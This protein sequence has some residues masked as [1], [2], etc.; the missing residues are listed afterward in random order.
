M[1]LG[2][3]AAVWISH[4]GPELGPSIRPTV[5]AIM[6]AVG[7]AGAV[8]WLLRRRIT[9]GPLICA[10][11]IGLAL[12]DSPIDTIPRSIDRAENGTVSSSG[13]RGLTKELFAGLRWIRQRTPDS[14]VIAVNNHFTDDAGRDPRAFQ[15]SAFS[16]RRVYL[17]SWRYTPGTSR[18]GPDR[19][20]KGAHPYP[21]LARI[22]AG[23]FNGNKRA[24]RALLRAG[25]T[26]LVLD[27]RYGPSPKRISRSAEQV[28]SNTALIV[29]KL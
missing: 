5:L 18:I 8:R 28:F 13:G 19:G 26:Y 6:L 7:L 11:L 12:L 4:R 16:E 24:L 25:V 23:A 3:A 1:G 17:Q 21:K 14:S 29:F 20:R 9:V 10:A 27:R 22:N 2:L 15:Y